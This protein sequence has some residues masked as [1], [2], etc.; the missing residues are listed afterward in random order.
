MY[1]KYLMKKLKSQRHIYQ[2]NKIE[3]E[4]LVSFTSNRKET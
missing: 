3:L 2:V 1:F 4:V